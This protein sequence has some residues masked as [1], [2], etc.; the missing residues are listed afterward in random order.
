MFLTSI[1]LLFLTSSAVA[2]V[3]LSRESAKRAALKLKPSMPDAFKHEEQ[4]DDDDLWDVHHNN[5]AY[6][7]KFGD[8]TQN[9][10]DLEHKIDMR[11]YRNILRHM[12]KLEV[13]LASALELTLSQKGCI[14]HSVTKSTDIIN[15]I[16]ELKGKLLRNKEFTDLLMT[17]LASVEYAILSSGDF[18][19]P[20]LAEIRSLRQ[21]LTK[22]TYSTRTD[23]ISKLT[24]YLFERDPQNFLK[25]NSYH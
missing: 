5:Y 24:K 22:N 18:K 21:G 14:Q 11:R 23:A 13:D 10:R 1:K 17:E 7:V 15:C 20:S 2:F 6:L 3:L 12:Y 19:N 25:T 9:L 8:L 4:A 16:R